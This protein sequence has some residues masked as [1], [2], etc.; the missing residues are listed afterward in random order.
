M[1]ADPALAQLSTP[2][3]TETTLLPRQLGLYSK[4]KA[5]KKKKNP[6]GYLYTQHTFGIISLAGQ[7]KVT[8]S[9]LGV[10]IPNV[11]AQRLH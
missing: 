6:T 2:D 10:P 11:H 7:S 9:V 5:Q 1:S 4:L 3:S 8:I